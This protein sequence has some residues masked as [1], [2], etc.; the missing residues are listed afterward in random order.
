M[1][2]KAGY[3]PP[4]ARNLAILRTWLADHAAAVKAWRELAGGEVPLD[5][6]VE[7]EAMAQL[8]DPESAELTELLKVVYPVT[9]TENLLAQ[10]T[11]NRQ[12]LAIPGDLRSLAGENQPPPKGYFSLL[13]R[14]QPES[15]KDLQVD[16]IPRIIGQVLVFGRQTD[17]EAR[18]ELI[19][20][21]KNMA[22]ARAALE[23]VARG[24]V[25]SAGQ[26]EVVSQTRGVDDALA[27]DWY[28]PADIAPT[29][30][31]SLLQAGHRQRLLIEWPDRPQL[32]FGGQTPRQAAADSRL[33]ITVLAAI[34]NL[35]LSSDM[36]VGFDFNEL[37]RALGL[38]ESPKID[39]AGQSVLTL[40]LVRLARLETTKLSDEDLLIAYDRASQA[41]FMHA[42]MLL[43]REIVGR[44]SLDAEVDKAAV[45][46]ML[47]QLANE[48]E[49]AAQDLDA[50]RKIAEGAGKST[51][52]FDL[53]ELAIH[54][55]QGDIRQA[56]RLLK[57]IRTDHL[58]EPGIAQALY[59]LL[60]QWGVI[61]PD[62]SPAT[63][64]GG[65]PAGLVVPG[66]EAEPAGKIWTPG[67]DTPTGGGKKSAIW[68]PGLD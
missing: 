48:P 31:R 43:G 26:A 65:E 13:D 2:D 40:P 67:S 68:T 9:E 59:S 14:P 16:A 47:A 34:L 63:E 29:E 8:L 64:R 46:A 58:R 30:R 22:P 57:H 62:G 17:R 20:T 66:A 27:L 55:G 52:R 53:I 19:T 56:D 6:A 15:A 32:L 38:P 45:Y 28:L 3:W 1:A 5:D 24:A 61:R 25:G 35:E 41:R 23:T 51:A 39:P 36:L 49:Q 42:I 4:I 7:A 54:M 50:G 18:A 44:A 37:R 10:L 11:T 60:A 12:S 21:E 33:R